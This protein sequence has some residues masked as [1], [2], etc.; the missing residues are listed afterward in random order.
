[1]DLVS[2]IRILLK[3]K[4][5]LI[6]IPLIVGILTFFLVRNLPDVFKAEAEISTGITESSKITLGSETSSSQFSEIQQKFSNII[7][8]MKSKKTYG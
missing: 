5:L 7:E 6:G 3:R 2:L 8:L 4:Y 1:M